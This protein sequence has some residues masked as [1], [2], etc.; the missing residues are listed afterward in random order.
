MTSYECAALL[1]TVTEEGI[2][3]GSLEHDRWKTGIFFRGAD[4]SVCEFEVYGGIADIMTRDNSPHGFTSGNE[5]SSPLIYI[6][7]QELA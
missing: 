1:D 6:G 3:I 2:V 7:A 4:N 5:V